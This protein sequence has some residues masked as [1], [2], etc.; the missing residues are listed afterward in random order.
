MAQQTGTEDFAHGAHQETSLLS[1]TDNSQDLNTSQRGS[2]LVDSGSRGGIHRSDSTISQSH[3]LTPSR[4]GTLKKKRSLSKKGSVKRSGSRRNSYAGSV[5]GLGAADQQYDGPNDDEMNSAFFTPVPTTGTPTEI[6]AERFQNWRKVLK[7]LITYFRDVQKSYESRSKALS[8][9]SN[10]ISNTTTPSVFLTHGGIGDAVHV[11]RDYHKQSISEANKAKTIEDDVVVQLTGLRSDLQQKI[12]EIKS[13]SGDFKNNVDRETEGTRRAVRDLQEALGAADADPNASHGRDDPYIIRLGVDRQLERQI[14]EENYLHRAFLNLESSGRELESI[15][16]GEIQKAY[17]ALAGILKREADEAYDTVERLRSGPV[18]MA[19]DHEWDAFVEKN[20]HFV[21]PRLPVRRVQNITYPGKDHAAAAEVRSGMLER[22]SKYLKSYTPGW[23]VLTPTHIHEFKSADRITSQV[24]IMSLHLAE[25]KLGSHSGMDS[26]SHKFMLKGRQTGGMHRGHAWVFRA[27]SHDT[28][29]A[30]FE[31]LKNLTEKT[32][33]E[34]KA[35]I[36][37]HARSLSGGSHKAPSISSEGMEEDEADQVPYSATASQVGQ[38]QPQEELPERPK[39]GGRFPSALNVN[40]DS[41]VPLSPSSPSSSD[42]KDAVAAAGG[43][44][45]SDVPFGSSGQRVES[46]GDETHSGELGGSS[47]TGAH[48][49]T[50]MPSSSKRQ[51]QYIAEGH[52]PVSPLS[53]DAERT[54]VLAREPRTAPRPGGFPQQIERHDSK[55]GDWMGPAAGGALTGAAGMEA[56]RRHEQQKER[57]QEDPQS[58]LLPVESESIGVN[59][60]DQAQPSVSQPPS[61]PAVAPSPLPPKEQTAPAIHDDI[62]TATF[63]SLPAKESRNEDIVPVAGTEYSTE[64]MQAQGV[65]SDGPGAVS[66]G[67]STAHQSQPE[68]QQNTFVP[69]SQQR[70]Y[71]GLHVQEGPSPT[72]M[73]SSTTLALTD[74]AGPV[75]ALADDPNFAM[76]R[77]PNLESHPSEATVSELHVPGEYPPTP[78]VSGTSSM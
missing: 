57:M 69:I 1:K 37:R 11:L 42:D 31:D 7:D 17:N 38:P 49:A 43:L 14:E 9:L 70:E 6:L 78:A 63:A 3:T 12:K 8:T 22:K 35:F 44:P 29:L 60:H 76:P 34:R 36:R 41:Q 62:T 2:T 27:E 56:Y 61:E 5:K 18:A 16:V 4:G 46:G 33:E 32:G 39:P 25:Q 77:R 59:A 26:S 65:S 30:W 13:L 52:D 20:E 45:G 64:P 75:K 51:A 73:F 23:Y 58:G 67:D 19:K 10:V 54:D 47:A 50:Y 55:Y 66:Y 48:P 21:D 72:S 68:Q 74:P 53:P 28:M 71:N 40:R 24:P 15:V